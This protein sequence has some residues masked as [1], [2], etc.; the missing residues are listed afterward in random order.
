MKVQSLFDLLRASQDLLQAFDGVDSAP[1][2]V[3][4]L[5]DLKRTNLEDLLADIENL[6]DAVD[7]GL[8]D[9]LELSG[10]QADG[11]ESQDGL[12]EALDAFSN[13]DGPESETSSEEVETPYPATQGSKEEKPTS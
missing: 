8:S 10:F 5:Q 3:S 12:Q 1:Q 7:S 13:L 11:D 2:L 6:R 4:R 9:T